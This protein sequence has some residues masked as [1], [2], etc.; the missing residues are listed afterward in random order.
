MELQTK[1]TVY[2]LYDA[3]G[4]LL[5]VGTTNNLE[6]RMASHRHDKQWWSDVADVETETVA[7]ATEAAEAERNQIHTLEPLHNAKHSG[8]YAEKRA[9]YMSSSL[10]GMKLRHS[11]MRALLSHR[12]LAILAGL[13]PT[14]VLKLENTEVSTPHP[15]TIRK[16]IDALGVEPSELLED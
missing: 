10:S 8:S 5:Y 11:R 13:S 14:T 12:E 6:R 1:Y 7:S 2:R 16:L 3:D 9:R 15:R 4:N